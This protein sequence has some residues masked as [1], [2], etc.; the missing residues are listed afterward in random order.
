MPLNGMW[1]MSMPVASL[2]AAADGCITR[3]LGA[4]AANVIGICYALPAGYPSR[5]LSS[6]L[7]LFGSEGVMLI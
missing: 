3:M 2:F 5:G 7:E 1:T 6:P 4:L